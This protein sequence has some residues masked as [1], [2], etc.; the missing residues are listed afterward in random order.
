MKVLVCVCNLTRSLFL[1]TKLLY[2][3]KF[4]KSKPGIRVK[5]SSETFEFNLFAESF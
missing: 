1:E 4:S 2:V 3:R 5:H